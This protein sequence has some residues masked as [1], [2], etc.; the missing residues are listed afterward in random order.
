MFG[1]LDVLLGPL[2]VALLENAADGVFT[3]PFDV[4][5]SIVESKEL[6]WDG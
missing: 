1:F 4:N 5:L 3:G 6:P 2:P